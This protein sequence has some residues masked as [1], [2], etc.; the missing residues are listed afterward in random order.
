MSDIPQD[1]ENPAESKDA[2]PPER[3]SPLGRAVMQ[4]NEAKIAALKARVEELQADV[5]AREAARLAELEAQSTTP[6]PPTTTEPD[7]P[8]PPDTPPVPTIKREKETGPNPERP[9][10]PEG[11]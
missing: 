6:P 3:L 8:K 5:E 11:A 2:A 9:S 4:G 10:N 7:P 1:T